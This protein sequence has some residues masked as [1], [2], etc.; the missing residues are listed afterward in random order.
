[1]IDQPPILQKSLELARALYPSAFQELRTFHVSV[2]WNKN[3][4]LSVGVNRR[5]TH[6]RNLI[7]KKFNR[8][9]LDISSEKLTCAEMAAF[10]GLGKQRYNLDFS[11]VIMVNLRYDRNYRLS[12]SKCCSSCQNLVKFL[13]LKR[14][15]YTDDQG[16]FQLD[17]V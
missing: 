13:G 11:K 10:L 17:K 9:G 14:V 6:P 12:M 1:M 16:K 8:E 4:L 15:Y 7:N 3:R 2:L 5:S